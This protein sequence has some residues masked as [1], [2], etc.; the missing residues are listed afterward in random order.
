MLNCVVIM[1]RLTA[2]PEL[3]TTNTGIETTRFTVAVDRTVAQGQDRQADFISCVAWRQSA[4]F[5]TKYFHKG[6]MIAIQG[7]IRTGSYVG[8]DGIK[9]YTTDV[10]VDRA[11]FCGSKAEAGAI[12]SQVDQL[13]ANQANNSMPTAYQSAG[14][15]DFKTEFPSDDGLPF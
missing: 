3:S 4:Q 2:E 14:T 10:V 12:S 11:S 13:A 15:E 6:S 7:N 1:G 8:K 5:I 9:R